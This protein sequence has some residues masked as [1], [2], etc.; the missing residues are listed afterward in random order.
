MLQAVFQLILLAAAA[1][2]SAGEPVFPVKVSANGRYI[3]DQR[4]AP[5]FW[6]GTT[7]WQLFRDYT[8]DEANLILDKSKDKGFVFLQVML[9]GVG[10]G[11]KVAYVRDLRSFQRG[12]RF[13]LVIM[14]QI[15]GALASPLVEYGR[16]ARGGTWASF[17]RDGPWPGGPATSG[18]SWHGPSPGGSPST[19]EPLHRS[20]KRADA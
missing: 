7:Q 17:D 20:R 9:M 15:L 4:G 18:G 16:R 14:A 19:R 3:V 2:A 6:L 11:T 12:A 8:L 1:S 10:D 5:V 13:P